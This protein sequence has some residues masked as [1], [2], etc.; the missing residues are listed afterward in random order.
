MRYIEGLWS[1][2]RAAWVMVGAAVWLAWRRAGWKWG[3][4]FGLLVAVTALAGLF[5]AADMS[6]T[7]MVAAPV[8]LLG[9][10]LWHRSSV[11][12]F[13]YALP[14]ILVANLLLPASHVVWTFKR[15]L[16][17]L[18]VEIDE[19][20]HPPQIVDPVAYVQR[21]D[22]IMRSGNL[23]LARRCFEVALRL[24]RD[25]A[26]AHVGLAK[27]RLQG[28]DTTGATSDLECA[29]R[30]R[31]G[32]PEAL[33]VRAALRHG[34]GDTQGAIDDLQES[35]RNAPPEWPTREHAQQLLDQTV[36]DNM[37]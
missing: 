5:V 20:L 12:T 18:Y 33:F 29:L 11:S 1:G 24:N 35:L 19:Y 6:R 27:V 26:P 3:L 7:L 4:P 23:A 15:P 17:Y 2:F 22:A 13:R 9:I 37:P 8:A 28:G 32:M 25:F 21:G 34:Q 36:R 16:R 30:L 10:L 31:P 14:A